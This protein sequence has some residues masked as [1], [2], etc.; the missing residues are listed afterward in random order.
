MNQLE[1]ESSLG[2]KIAAGMRDMKGLP[3]KR[4]RQ[5]AVAFLRERPEID[6]LHP[7]L[8]QALLD[9][10]SDPGL[11]LVPAG[12]AKLG[13]NAAARWW[14]YRAVNAAL[15]RTTP[16]A[17]LAPFAQALGDYRRG[18]Y[19]ALT[20]QIEGHLASQEDLMVAVAAGSFKEAS[21]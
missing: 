7:A 15:Y 21:R 12:R 16:S 5:I 19:P 2:E 1:R 8:R 13:K 18:L 6:I 17:I 11:E 4:A 10:T 14:Y 9:G 20:A 3:L